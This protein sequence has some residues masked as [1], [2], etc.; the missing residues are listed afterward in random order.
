MT[1][2]QYIGLFSK[3]TPQAVRSEWEG[4]RTWQA[5]RGDRGSRLLL[6]DAATSLHFPETC[7]P[8]STMRVTAVL[9]IY[10]SYVCG[11]SFKRKV[12]YLWDSPPDYL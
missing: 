7:F 3:T 10:S 4:P 5:Q 2:L 11:P 1:R 6:S 9:Y 8:I 12:M